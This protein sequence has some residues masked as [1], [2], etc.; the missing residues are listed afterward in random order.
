[1]ITAVEIDKMFQQLPPH[2][3]EPLHKTIHGDAL[4]TLKTLATNSVHS[5]VTDP[6]AGIAFMGKDWDKDKGGRDQWIAWLTEIMTESLRV[7][8]P[9]AHG[10]IWAL[11]RTSH[12]TATA[13]ENAGFE[14]RDIVTHIFGSGF[15]S[16]NHNISKA[17]D[18][19]AGAEREVIGP[20][21]DSDGR[22]RA[23]ETHAKTSNICRGNSML[24]SKST[25]ANNMETAPSTP[26]AKQWD[27]WGTALKP[28]N[29]H[30]ILVRKPLEKKLT[31]AKN[32]LKHGTGGINIDGSRVSYQSDKDRSTAVPYG[33]M[34]KTKVYGGSSLLESKTVNDRTDRTNDLGRFP[35]NTIVDE[36]AV[37]ELDGQSGI[38]KTNPGTYKSD[39]P[40]AGKVILEK[41]NKKG[42]VTSLGD[43][44]GA[45][46]FFYCPKASKKDK[47][48]NN[49]HP[50]V[51]NTKLMAYLVNMV[52]PPGGTVL[53]P[54]MG[55]GSTGVAAKREGFKFIGIESDVGSY[56][57]AK[58]RILFQ[59][60]G[61][62][63]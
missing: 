7:L 17:I 24:E 58:D 37:E 25:Q 31:V 13:L 44:G 41:E 3:R 54:F 15:P 16:K 6:P 48:Q 5:I 59:L 40:K 22:I 52:T 18:K 19:Q 8:K 2:L 23:S 53:D 43:S 45:S 39:R 29:E 4:E 11:P 50:T 35:A 33:D 28:S 32:V 14:I 63:T 1:L 21:K 60:K 36:S 51:K 42:Y 38:L 9:G 30:W 26:E 61:A 57:F 27:G 56:N 49:K 55:S 20:K 34:S 62:L 12:W 10:F 47:G 46:R